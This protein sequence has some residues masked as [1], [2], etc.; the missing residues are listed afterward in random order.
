MRSRSRTNEAAHTVAAADQL[1][2]E[3]QPDKAG[4]AGDNDQGHQSSDFKF[5]FES[6]RISIFAAAGQ[7]GNPKSGI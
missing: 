7:I 2:H 5:R 1:F 6:S 3:V 4:A